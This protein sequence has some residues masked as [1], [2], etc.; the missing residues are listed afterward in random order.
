MRENIRFGG[1]RG[2][3]GYF[4]A[5][6]P[7]SGPGVVIFDDSGGEEEAVALADRL[8][9]EERLT[10]LVPEVAGGSLPDRGQMP[11]LLREAVDHLRDNWHPRVG[12]MAFGS[13]AE[14]AA[15][16]AEALRVD[17]LVLHGRAGL[18]AGPSGIPLLVHL[19]ATAAERSADLFLERA[20]TDVH[21]YDDGT[22]SPADAVTGAVWERNVEFLR[23]HLS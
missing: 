19:D 5:T 1:L 12:L 4:S 20:D 14:V 16:Y 6:V 2:A 10:V 17:A 15:G 21:L 13:C 22:S 18:E 23:Y 9:S 8:T 3:R 11:S 7:R